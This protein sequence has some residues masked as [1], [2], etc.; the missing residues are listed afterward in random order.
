MCLYPS[1][2]DDRAVQTEGG[3]TSLVDHLVAYVRGAVGLEGV[4]WRPGIRASV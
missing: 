4:D 1:V 2:L 3:S